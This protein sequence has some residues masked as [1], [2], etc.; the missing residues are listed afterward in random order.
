[1]AKIT[2]KKVFEWLLLALKGACIGTGAILPGVSGGVLCV[3]F[4]IYEPMMA[5]LSHPFKAF[6][7]YY[8]MF[9][10]VIFGFAI[11][12]VLLARG[13][14]LLFAK[15]ETVALSLFAGLICGAIPDLMKKSEISGPKQ[16][17]SALIIPMA[18]IFAFLSFMQ[19]ES[20]S[21]ITPSA[22]WFAFC[23]I[24]W[25]LSMVIPGLSSSSI[26]IFM[27]I[28]Q[29]MT[30]GIAALDFSVILPLG[31][32]IAASVLLTAR[33]VNNMFERNFALISRMIIGIMIASTL[34]IIPTSFESAGAAL[35]CVVCFAAGFAVARW[36][37]K[38]RGRQGEQPSSADNMEEAK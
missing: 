31:V 34:L 11:G 23:G 2:G 38:A 9:I 17:W 16:S 7:R 21:A 13:V 10:P 4:G 24:V 18:A 5:L 32:G 27:G 20:I 15:S 1:M 35:L 6:K 22:S 36:M 29:P 37:D 3:A 12:F 30:A 25:G 33:L 14:E 8:R 26:L 19:A 28:Y